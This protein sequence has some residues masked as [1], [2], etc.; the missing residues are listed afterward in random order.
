MT[1]GTLDATC[2]QVGQSMS[3]AISCVANLH[4]ST[5]QHVV[6]LASVLGGG[7]VPADVPLVEGALI[8]QLVTKLTRI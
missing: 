6:R 1:R 4:L 8:R 3:A 7:C 5:I 2:A